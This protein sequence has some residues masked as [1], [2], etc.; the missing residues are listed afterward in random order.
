MPALLFQRNMNLKYNRKKNNKK[1][2]K[3]D[4]NKEEGREYLS[5]KCAWRILK[6]VREDMSN[7]SNT[8]Q[9]MGPLLET[10]ET[11]IGP[12]P[13][14][15]KGQKN[16]KGRGTKKLPVHGIYDRHTG[17]VIMNIMY[18]DPNFKDHRIAGIQL[19][20]NIDKYCKKN[21]MI[22]SDDFSGYN[23]LDKPNENNFGH[24]SVN[25]SKYKFQLEKGIH[26]NNI[27][28]KWIPL[29]RGGL[30]HRYHNIALKYLPFYINEYCFRLNHKN[31]EKAF[32]TF[33]EQSVIK[34]P[35]VT[36]FIIQS[37]M[38]AQSY[39]RVDCPLKQHF[40]NPDRVKV[41]KLID[42]H[43][44]KLSYTDNNGN[45]IYV[46]ERSIESFG[47]G[48]GFDIWEFNRDFSVDNAFDFLELFDN[49]QNI[50]ELAA[51]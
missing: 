10:D 34:K 42:M 1:K 11:Y 16:K 31:A 12:K 48:C 17:N 8:Y 9:M 30:Y 18:P 29:K 37:T 13:K 25:H 38:R 33:L 46:L 19:K 22:I 45:V 20:A 3:E 27:E 40:I 2:K 49:E 26:T 4:S 35:K 44:T 15:V 47:F 39:A 28:Q 36:P 14:K 43:T 7:N 5:Y 6:K 24:Y 50:N 23:F 51:A 21:S 41:L 32:I